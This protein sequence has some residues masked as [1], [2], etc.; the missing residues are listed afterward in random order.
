MVGHNKL[1][2]NQSEMNAA[3]EYYLNNVVLKVPCTVNGVEISQR[4]GESDFE[5][6]IM[7]RKDEPLKL[8][9]MFANGTTTIKG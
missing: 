9:E 3:I 8:E 1:F 4:S 5:I 2:I 6:K 7:P